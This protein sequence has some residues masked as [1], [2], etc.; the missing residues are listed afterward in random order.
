MGIYNN[1]GTQIG[2]FNLGGSWN[3]FGYSNAFT[4]TTDATGTAKITFDAKTK[5][6]IVG[7]ANI[8]LKQGTTNK[9]TE[10]IKIK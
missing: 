2:S 3:S 6:G 7:D 1:N 8:R 9:Y 4:F 10:A 5:V